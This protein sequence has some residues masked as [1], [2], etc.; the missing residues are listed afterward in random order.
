MARFR[1]DGR[2]M[3]VQIRQSS[4]VVNRTP[5]ARHG[6]RPTPSRIIEHVIR[7]ERQPPA[8]PGG[9]RGRRLDA[10]RRWSACSGSPAAGATCPTH[11][12]PVTIFKPL[13]GLDEGLEENLR[14]FFQLDYPTYQLL[15]CVAD[16]DDPAIAVVQKLLAEFPDH[17]AQLVVGCP[18]FGLN[19]KVE[20]LAAMDRYRK[21][22]VILISDSN[23]RVRPS[24]PPR[25][26]LLP[27]RAGGRAGDEPVRRAWARRTPARCMENLQLNGFIAGGVA[28]ASVLRVTC[29]VGKSMLMPVAGPRGD[30]RVRRRSATCWPRT[31]SSASGSARRAT[32]SG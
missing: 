2:V 6:R 10:A 12:P 23:V 17:D 22:D 13:K 4:D 21:H 11:T 19:P 29:V 31:R 18:A 8:R 15:F 30:R 27:G 7:P 28:L 25:D 1:L 26:G 16:A 20:N 24:L 5:D 14:S 3:P 32:R 9:R